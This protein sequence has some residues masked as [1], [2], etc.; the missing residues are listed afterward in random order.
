M[1][2]VELNKVWQYSKNG[3]NCRAKA[4]ESWNMKR[5]VWIAVLKHENSLMYYSDGSIYL[6]ELSKFPDFIL[7]STE[8]KEKMH[9]YHH[10]Y[11]KTMNLLLY[12]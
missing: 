9:A 7:S 12:Q 1:N 6:V 10:P 8:K 4:S 11:F 5:V 2:Q 3:A